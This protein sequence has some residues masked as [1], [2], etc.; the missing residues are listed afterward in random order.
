MKNVV[1]GRRKKSMLIHQVILRVLSWHKR[2]ATFMGYV[3][4]TA[5]GVG[6]ASMTL[7]GRGDTYALAFPQL[8][9]PSIQLFVF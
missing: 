9:A 3:S 2:R 8:T 5:R 6:N 4:I 7:I 1:C